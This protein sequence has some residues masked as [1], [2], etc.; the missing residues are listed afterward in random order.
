MNSLKSLSLTSLLMFGNLIITNANP[1]DTVYLD[2]LDTYKDDFCLT[3]QTSANMDSTSKGGEWCQDAGDNLNMYT[4]RHSS[5]II[6]SANQGMYGRGQKY[7][8]GE[9]KNSDTCYAFSIYKNTCHFFTYVQSAPIKYDY[10]Q[11]FT[12]TAA[13]SKCYIQHTFTKPDGDTTDISVDCNTAPSSVAVPSI[14][15][16]TVAVP[17][18]QNNTLDMLLPYVAQLVNLVDGSAIDVGTEKDC[19]K[20]RYN[21]IDG[22]NSS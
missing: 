10:V 13:A 1:D 16:N 2:Y 18:I 19:L 9:C 4:Q 12:G 20:A 3:K 14:Q 5:I 15:S 21:A 8:A 17:S 11:G 7:C 6:P 22:C